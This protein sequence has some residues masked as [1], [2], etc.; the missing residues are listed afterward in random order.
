MARIPSFEDLLL[1]VQQSLGVKH[2]KLSTTLEKRRYADLGFRLEKHVD[3]STELLK[4]IFEALGLDE[5]ACSYLTLNLMEWG[6]FNKALALRTWTCNASQKQVLWHLLAYVYVP[7]LA[8]RVAFWS[9][10]DRGMRQPLDAGMPGASFW[11]LP[12]WERKANTLTLPVPHVLDW[13]FDLLGHSVDQTGK[14]I[15]QGHRRGEEASDSII[16]TLHNWRTGTLPNPDKIAE[17]LPDNAPLQFEGIFEPD[18]QSPLADRFQSAKDFIERR[19]LDAYKLQDKI[20]MKQDL[21][22]K[23]LSG[24]AAEDEKQELVDLLSTRYAKPEMATI[25]LR[26]RVARMV[27]DGYERLLESLC[28]G[29]EKTCADPEK[30][31]L[32]QLIV[33]FENVYN[34]TIEANK[35]GA[36][37]AEENA[38]FEANLQPWDKKDLLLSIV[39]SRPTYEELADH[40]TRKFQTL[41]D[42]DEQLEDLVPIMPG[43]ASAIVERRWRAIEEFARLTKL[44]ERIRRFL[45]LRELQSEDNFW[46]VS[47]IAGDETQPFKVREMAVDRM[48]GLAQTQDETVAAIYHNLVRLQ[49]CDL[50]SIPKD[51]EARVQALLDETR[52][53]A[54]LKHWK[55]PI[56]FRQAKHRLAQND[57]RG[58]HSDFKAAMQACTEYSY[59][60]LRGKA[61]MHTWALGIVLDGLVPNNQDLYYRNMLGYMELEFPQGTP[62]SFEETAAFCEEH[63]WTELYR[64]YPGKESSKPFDPQAAFTESFNLVDKGDQDGLRA[65]LKRRAKD[66]RKKP[67]HEARQNSVLLQWMK[68]Q[69]GA[70]KM[71]SDIV[72]IKSSIRANTIVRLAIHRE[73]RREAMRILLAEWPEQANLADFKGQTPLTLAADEGDADLVRTLLE[74]GADVDA[75]DY[76]GRTALHG[77]VTGRSPECVSL[78]LD[79]APK[80]SSGITHD[81][82]NTALHTAVRMGQAACV[83]LIADEFPSLVSQANNTGQTPLAMARNILANLPAWQKFMQEKHRQ[84]GSRQDFEKMIFWLEKQTTTVENPA[85]GQNSKA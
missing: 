61:A 68:W 48:H 47:R 4:D 43:K 50:K 20:P 10:P 72:R 67:L 2:P 26:L 59:G 52:Q 60:T 32:L 36:T 27:Q 78:I 38:W 49:D 66:F 77:A 75:Q 57:L 29:V 22:E 82:G 70:G 28:P 63:F 39:P 14:F 11:F 84:T 21:L 13:L 19:G 6:G 53:H 54:D 31:K 41:S 34:L 56:L 8:R 35:H 1:E 15:A 33:L 69:Y 9:L 16:R 42:S 85:S 71:L 76:L 81:E 17:H 40:L 3:I 64:P 23:I 83:R 79:R 5:S 80:A 37:E 12:H 7:S 73:K 51:V 55:A 18:E 62:S 46:V 65:W 30:N 24:K 45:P 58:A 25:R 44:R 74:A